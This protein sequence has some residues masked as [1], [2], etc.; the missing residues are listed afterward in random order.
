M[1]NIVNILAEAGNEPCRVD[2]V[3]LHDTLLRLPAKMYLGLYYMMKAEIE[4]RPCF[5]AL[6]GKNEP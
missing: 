3:L 1:E 4:G 2:L 5:I 6:S